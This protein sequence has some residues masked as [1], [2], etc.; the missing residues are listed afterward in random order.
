M[1]KNFLSLLLIFVLLAMCLSGCSLTTGTI[2]DL[3][4]PPD[5]A[6]DNQGLVKVLEEKVSEKT[7]FSSPK[8]G[9]YRSSVVSKDIDGD[10]ISEALTFYYK[11]GK[12]SKINMMLFKHIDNDWVS[13]QNIEGQ[14]TDIYSIDFPDFNN[15]GVLEVAVGWSSDSNKD[16][17]VMTVYSYD[18]K[19]DEP[20][21]TAFANILYSTAT[22]VDLNNDQKDELL[23]C[24]VSSKLEET[25][26]ATATLYG[27][28]QNDNF[29]LMGETRMDNNVTSYTNI[30]V[31]KAAGEDGPIL[32][33]DGTKG[34][35]L[36][37]TETVKWDES[38]KMLTA[39]LYDASLSST[40]IT[41]RGVRVTTRD[42]NDDGIAEIPL[43]HSLVA[44]SDKKTYLVRWKQVVG[45]ELTQFKTSLINL[46]D[47]Y[48]VHI[49]DSLST[50]IFVEYSADTKEWTVKSWDLSNNLP[51]GD[52]LTIKSVSRAQW[53]IDKASSDYTELMYN[54]RS[55]YIGKTTEL[56]KGYN[57]TVDYLLNN[58]LIY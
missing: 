25:V 58:I 21:T 37:V 46:N 20:L 24:N 11:I 51:E 1:K 13:I 19:S 32:Y 6:D 36:M 42:V 44:D 9:E 29:A 5:T 34:D 52:L 30:F 50:K 17:R 54:G 27:Y 4:T 16:K 35:N 23:F 55:V 47:G 45:R 15:D 41:S 18:T 33:V 22:V 49:D 57:I 12:N 56:A 2:D 26:N 38:Q 10:G 43:D 40:V 7:T 31:Q 3:I 39:P 53:K 28:N 48:M 14:G 8:Y